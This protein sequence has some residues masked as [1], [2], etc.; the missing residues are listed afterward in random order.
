MLKIILGGIVV[1]MANIIPGVSGGTM[2][3]IFGIF[4]PVMAAISSLTS[5]K[6]KDKLK[7][8]KYVGTLL[9]GVAIGL[10]VFSRVVEYTLSVVPTQ[11][12]FCFLGMI[13]FS[14]PILKRKEMQNEKF[15]LVP[16]VVGVALILLMVYFA[17]TEENTVITNFPALDAVYLV[18]MVLIGMVA[19]AA[20]FVPGVSGSMLLLILG[21]YYLFNSLI[22]N[23]TS[24]QMVVLVPLAMLAFGILIGIILSSK[25]T[26]W[27][28]KKDH[29]A[30]MNFIMGLVVA[31]CVMIIPFDAVYDLGT[32]A[33]SAI[34]LAF[35]G[36]VVVSIEKFVK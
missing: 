3:A 6:S 8:I 2:M 26:G 24:F 7:H 32:I 34:A 36:A 15:R 35:G 12:L 19:G 22:A 23:A 5:L 16:F 14:I 18:R 10:L 11:T 21:E 9:I 27:A 33:T 28:L 20:M 17:P 1:G 13:L 30:T 25:V 31:S 4:N 29:E